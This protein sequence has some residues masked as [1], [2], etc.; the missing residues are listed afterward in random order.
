MKSK[1]T[2][3]LACIILLSSFIGC[4]DIAGTLKAR[5]NKATQSTSATSA[6]N[7]GNTSEEQA[8]INAV[9]EKYGDLREQGSPRI[10]ELMLCS[11]VVNHIPADRVSQYSSNTPKFYAWF[12]YDNFN[13]ATIS[14]EPSCPGSPFPPSCAA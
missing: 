7:F 4:K 8:M 1:F 5:F 12:I 2:L 11:S 3:V 10:L 6:G 9:T 14:V 13:E